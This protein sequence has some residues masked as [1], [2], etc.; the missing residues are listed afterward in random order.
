MDFCVPELG[1]GVYEAELVEWSVVP[2]DEVRQ[3]QVL[4]EVMTDKATME[5]PSPF[6]GTI[7]T[8]L[9][10]PGDKIAIQQAVLTYAPGE[11]PRE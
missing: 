2:G 7:E 5:L 9:V 4:A 6:F 1:E 11:A 8:L 3:G 10:S